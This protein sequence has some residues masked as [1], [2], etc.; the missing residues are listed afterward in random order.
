TGEQRL[1]PLSAP[2]SSYPTKPRP[3]AHRERGRV[4]C[5]EYRGKIAQPT[6]YRA[7]RPHSSGRAT[8][9]GHLRHRSSWPHPEYLYYH[10]RVIGLIT[11]PLQ[12]TSSACVKQYIKI[13]Y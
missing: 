11:L 7:P 6:L 4:A 9:A 10:L 12:S 3:A 5:G 2:V 13:F 1:L 8:H